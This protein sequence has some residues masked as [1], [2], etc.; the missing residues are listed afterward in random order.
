MK[1]IALCVI[2]GISLVLPLAASAQSAGPAADAK[3]CQALVDTFRNVESSNVSNVDIPMAMEACAH[4]DTAKGIPVLEQ[5][6][7]SRRV[8]LPPR[9]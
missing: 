5:A 6:L 7:R 4:G 9:D 8:A 1:T 3:Y 2:A